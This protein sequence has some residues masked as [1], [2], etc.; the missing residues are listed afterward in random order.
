MFNFSK[1]MVEADALSNLLYLAI[2]YLIIQKT[3]SPRES[4]EDVMMI[5][6]KGLLLYRVNRFSKE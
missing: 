5:T 2:Y 6:S 4:E 3:M 1:L